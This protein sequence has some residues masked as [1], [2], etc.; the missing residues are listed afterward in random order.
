M[1]KYENRPWCEVCG[2]SRATAFSFFI[3]DNSLTKKGWKFC[4]RCAAK[5]EDYYI[6]I[7]EYFSGQGYI[8]YYG[9]QLKN[10][11]WFDRQDFKRMKSRFRFRG[12]V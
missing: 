12:G 2:E 11:T 10:K 3:K 6:E 7:E 5:I 8:E 4:C 9:A 1:L